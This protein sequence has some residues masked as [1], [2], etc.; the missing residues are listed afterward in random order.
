MPVGRIAD[1][2]KIM[3]G[4]SDSF[5]IVGYEPSIDVPGGIA[6]LLLAARRDGALAYVG[7]F[8]RLKH[9]EARRLRIHMDKL[10]DRSRSSR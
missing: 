2:L 3:C 1:W 9:D 10:I 4:Q 8:G 7:S 5:V 6:S